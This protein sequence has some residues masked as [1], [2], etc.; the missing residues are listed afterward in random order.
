MNSRYED[1]ESS[2]DPTDDDSTATDS[3]STTDDSEDST[4]S[5]DSS[6]DSDG[7]L[8]GYETNRTRPSS[9]SCQ[10]L[11][12]QTTQSFTTTQMSDEDVEGDVGA[13]GG[14]GGDTIMADGATGRRVDSRSAQWSLFLTANLMSLRVPQTGSWTYNHLLGFVL[15]YRIL[16][17]RNSI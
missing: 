9:Y 1:S 7:K 2:D 12:T 8:V 17:A 13:I 15:M 4:E 10:T 3:D 5:S 11:L 6:S 16:K 14:T